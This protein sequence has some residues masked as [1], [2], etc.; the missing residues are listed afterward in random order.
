[1]SGGNINS[2]LSPASANWNGIS[3][4]GISNFGSGSDALQFEAGMSGG[5]RRR[6]KGKR[7]RF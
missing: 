3:G 6:K 7:V 5:K 1:M 2:I 4:A